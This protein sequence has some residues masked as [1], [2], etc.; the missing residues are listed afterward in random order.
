MYKHCN[1]EE[2]ARRQRQLEQCLLDLMRTEGYVHITIGSICE[3]AGISRKSFYRYF[4][5]KDGCLYALLD[6][7]IMDAAS[8][9]IP[10]AGS[11][12]SSRQ[13]FERFLSYWKNLSPLLDALYK[14]NLSSRLVERMMV[15]ITEEEH[16]FQ[17][18]L[19]TRGSSYEQILF[20]V[21]GTMGLVMNWH[22]TNYS[23]DVGQ[24]ASVLDN[25]MVHTLIG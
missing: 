13:V 21:T 3:H 19:S 2:S 1:T 5:S 12:L 16:A 23:K 8:F 10:E 11:H 22:L 6:H 9:C 4:G 18:L 17:Q 24:I 15:Y 20:I 7:A 14:N 25:L